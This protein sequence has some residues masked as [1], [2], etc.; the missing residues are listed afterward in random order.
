M[1]DL[2]AATMI[3]CG[4][5]LALFVA[6]SV[7]VPL[8]P[9]LE[10]DDWEGVARNLRESPR[11]LAVVTAPGIGSLA[12]R[13]YEPDLR[14]LFGHVRVREVAFVV[15]DRPPPS[16][17]IRLRGFRRAREVGLPS[18]RIEFLTAAHPTDVSAAR[19]RAA[20]DAAGLGSLVPVTSQVPANE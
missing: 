20:A 12:L 7:A 4:G 3:V 2:R 5:L 16:V 14:P 9:R 11:P 8:T 18:A 17:R 1:S 10:R 19:L 6:V 13:L 15:V